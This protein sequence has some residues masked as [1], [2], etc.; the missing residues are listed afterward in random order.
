MHTEIIAAINWLDIMEYL[1]G[2]WYLLL[3]LIGFS[4][5]IFVHELGHFLMAKLV[6]IR[7]ETF[8]IGF[9]PR[10]VGF[11][12]GDTDYCI[13]L[14]PLGGYV[15][16]LGQE[17]FAMDQDRVDATKVDPASFLAKTPGQRMLVVS[18]GVVMN[19]IFAAIAFVIIFMHGW[20]APAAVAGRVLPESPAAKAGIEPGDRFL[21]INGKSILKFS[22][23]QLAIALSDPNQP[24]DIEVQRG[25]KIVKMQVQPLYSKMAEIQ[26]I[27]VPGAASLVVRE[28]G[29][30][31]P[32]QANLEPKDVIVGVDSLK[33]RFSHEVEEKLIEAAGKPVTLTVQRSVDGQKRLVKVSKRAHLI[34]LAEPERFSTA[35][36]KPA[37]EEREN[38]SILGLVPRQKFLFTPT[39]E[40]QGKDLSEYAQ[41]GDII[42]KVDKISNPS[43]QELISYLKSHR[44]D[45]IAI[46]VQRDDGSRKTVKL[47]VPLRKY[48]FG[49]LM[50]EF[51]LDDT[52]AVVSDV[53]KGSP[54]SKLNMP[55]GAK[56]L[57][58]GGKD[59]ST[60]FDLVEWFRSHPGQEAKIT[61]EA[62][63]K[64]QTGT[65][66]I[67]K[68]SRWAENVTYAIDFVTNPLT[69]T[70]KGKNPIEAIML[71]C[72]ETWS[73]IK[74]AYVMLQRLTINRTIGAKQL[75][76]PIFIIYKGKEVAEAG[77]Y[78][79]LYYL[80][81]ISANLA[82]INF[83]P[84][85]V[86]DGGLMIILL[87]EKVRGRGL[88]PRSTAVWQ[89]VGLSLIIALFAF[90]TYN[91]IARLIR[92]Q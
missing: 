73:F 37:D 53:V 77:F 47:Y 78:T 39:V 68:D 14:L 4:I 83:L 13:R 34:I 23:L 72:R 26:Q 85:P 81:L 22:E 51:G 54:A 91:D 25:K 71:G 67:P 19:V 89:A 50:G 18:G 11:K 82:V 7:V 10:L 20:E 33:P 76:G 24:M 66:T 38:L 28:P 42:L 64:V 21:T 75:S 59:V 15:K 8:A 16:M 3:V 86:V 74:S 65:M 12:R 5:I 17:D 27:G 58:C 84:M 69:T 29:M 40:G 80:A 90:V 41:A 52:H 55:R 49:L 6:G 56:I 1:K 30:T 60:W 88:S 31:I 57:T 35:A 48:Y 36:S 2:A 61:F 62:D 87:L 45:E 9:G 44:G 70:I 63:G 32:G 46:D 92:G 43:E 79:L